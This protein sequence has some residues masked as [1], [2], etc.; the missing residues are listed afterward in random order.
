MSSAPV[1]PSSSSFLNADDPSAQEILPSE[2]PQ[3]ILYISL[4]QDHTC[5]AVGTSHGFYVFSVDPLKDRFHKLWG[6]GIGIIEMLMRC[7][8]L[9]L[10]GGGEQPKFLKNRLI[11]WDDFQN[12][13]IAELEFSSEVKGVKLRRE[14]VCVLL[15]NEIHIYHFNNLSVLTSLYSVSNNEA[16]ICALNGVGD[17]VLGCCSTKS[18]VLHLE[19][20]DPTSAKTNAMNIAAHKTEISCI[21]ISI[22]GTLIATASAKGTL[23][24]VFET[25]RG[26][27]EREFRRGTQV[28]A[29]TSLNFTPDNNFLLVSSGTGTVH[30]FDV[31]E[32]GKN[33]DRSMIRFHTTSPR[34]L[35]CF[36]TEKTTIIVIGYDGKYSRYSY[37]IDRGQLIPRAE[38]VDYCLL[39]CT[40]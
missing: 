18:G 40:P 7:N 37:I 4:N 22:D 16:G 20:I 8:I 3:K 26:R 19:H 1:S 31:C 21:G 9:A 12:R 32:S 33:R 29:I 30:V 36:G 25:A 28:M 10:V 24:R 14:I 13:A 34:T 35:S 17:I 27:L 5:F 15:D 39:T 38:V 23:I 11:I 6:M 2:I